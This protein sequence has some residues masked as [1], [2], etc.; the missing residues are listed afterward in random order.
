MKHMHNVCF[1]KISI[2]TPIEE[3]LLE[4]PREGGICKGQKVKKK[5]LKP[6]KEREREGGGGVQVQ[7]TEPPWERYGYFLEQHNQNT[8]FY[9]RERIRIIRKVANYFN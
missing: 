5:V 7:T 1:Q 3:G 4:N 2:P 6:C 8:Y 9:F